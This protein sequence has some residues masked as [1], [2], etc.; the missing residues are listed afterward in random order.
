MRWLDGPLGFYVSAHAR[1]IHVIDTYNG[2]LKVATQGA[3]GKYGAWR[4]L[5]GSG[6][7][8]SADGEASQASFTQ[9]HGMDVAPNAGFAY[10]GDTFA[11]CVR[12]VELA[13]GRVATVAGRC[14]QGGHRD[15]VAGGGSSC[16]DARFNHGACSI[17]I[18]DP[19]RP[20]SGCVSQTLPMRC[21]SQC[22][23]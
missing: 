13:T 20:A 15:V 22:T 10:I 19:R 4:T 9:P 8:G 23:R 2:K 12:S 11:M 3:D 1:S 18:A 17:A 14:G 21:R 7:I 16:L 5:A 6:A